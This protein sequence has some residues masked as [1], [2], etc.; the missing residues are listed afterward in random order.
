MATFKK[1]D[2]TFEFK[3]KFSI[4]DIFNVIKEWAKENNLKEKET[5]DESFS[6]EPL[7]YSKTINFAKAIVGK[8]KTKNPLKKL[9]SPDFS[10]KFEVTV[11]ISGK[12]KDEKIDGKATVSIS[13]TIS[14]N[15]KENPFFSWKTILKR[16]FIDV[17]LKENDVRKTKELEKVMDDLE[18]KINK[19]L[20]I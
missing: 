18:K 4:R 5:S 17:Y 19:K 7:S 16:R 10:H 11:K 15:E 12:R 1:I 20:A 14:D 9:Y 6:P 2:K 13:G 8:S 3:G